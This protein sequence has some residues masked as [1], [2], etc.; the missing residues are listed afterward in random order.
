MRSNALAIHVKKTW[1]YSESRY[2]GK[3]RRRY[4]KRRYRY[5]QEGR[6][7]VY[8]DE[9]GF[10]PEVVRTHGWAKRGHK[11]HGFRPGNT[12]PRTSLIA[13]RMG[14]KLE[15]PML[16]EG[17]CNTN[18]FY[19]WVVHCLCPNLQKGDVVVMDN[20]SFHKAQKIR[21]AIEAAEALL[22]F[23]PPY[24]PDRNPIET[25]FANLKHIRIYNEHCSID[26]AINMYG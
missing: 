11:V 8:V 3:C 19:D 16:F 22:L 20:A 1:R 5:Q 17:C 24:S 4:L 12:R 6:R 18:I 21:D 9:S 13:A 15:A 10:E 23:L 7:F 25:D 26:Q 14:G 2:Y